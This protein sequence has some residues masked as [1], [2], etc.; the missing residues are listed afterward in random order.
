MCDFFDDDFDALDFAFIAGYVETQIE[1]EKEQ[2][3][4]E[5]PL[6]YKKTA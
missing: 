1:G 3:Q 4:D 5:E 2:E 6:N